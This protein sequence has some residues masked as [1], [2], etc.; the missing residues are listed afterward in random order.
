MTAAC[1]CHPETQIVDNDPSTCRG[2]KK[3]QEPTRLL[4]LFW[5]Q[6]RAAPRHS[7]NDFSLFVDM[8]TRVNVQAPSKSA[9][10]GPHCD[11]RANFSKNAKYYG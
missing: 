4:M 6:R 3:A 1:G 11:G 8:A 10:I 9:K 5:V 2:H 7:V